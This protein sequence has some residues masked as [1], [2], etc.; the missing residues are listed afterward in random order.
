MRIR[1]PISFVCLFSLLLPN[2]ALSQNIELAPRTLEQRFASASGNWAATMVVGIRYA[3]SMGQT[4]EDFGRFMAELALPGWGEPGSRK[5]D[6][7]LGMHAGMMGFPGAEYEIV[8]QT[9]ESVTARSNRPWAR[10][11]GENGM[12]WG[13]S[14]EE[15]ESVWS[16]FGNALADRFGLRYE[17]WV[18]DEW[19]FQRLSL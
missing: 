5:L 1:P 11:F 14:L 17:Q 15:F 9:G 8:E 13:V 12:F 3:Q 19:L 7:I 6:V 18:E 2:C 16:V 4:A 10:D